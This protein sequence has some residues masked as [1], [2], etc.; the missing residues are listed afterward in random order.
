MANEA[1]LMFET[2]L[3]IPFICA[4][5]T[6][7]PYGTVV[8]GADPFTVSASTAAEDQFGGIAGAEKIASDGVTT[9]PVY[10]S[11]IFK[12]FASGNVKYGDPLVTAVAVDS[13]SNYFASAVGRTVTQ[14]SGNRIFGIALETATAGQTFLMELR[15]ET[16]PRT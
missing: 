13:P 14:L 10:R 12:V 15:P 6:A 9:V 1:V 5:A 2:S 8:K 16:L 4:N 11:G 7:I 3:P